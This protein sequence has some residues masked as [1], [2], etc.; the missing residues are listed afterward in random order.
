MPKHW[1]KMF[2]DILNGRDV[3]DILKKIA[4]VGSG[5]AAPAASGAASSS[6]AAAAAAE[7]E[8]PEAQSRKATAEPSAP[9]PRRSGARDPLQLCFVILPSCSIIHPN[10]PIIQRLNLASLNGR[11]NPPPKRVSGRMIGLCMLL[12]FLCGR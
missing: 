1:T 8:E 3:N 6:G 2:A 9:R 11:P 4:S 12:E 10:P 5:A 7:P